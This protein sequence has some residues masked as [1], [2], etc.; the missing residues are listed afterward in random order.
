MLTPEYERILNC[1]NLVD[2]DEIH[3]L[4]LAQLKFIRN[5]LWLSN[6]DLSDIN[7]AKYSDLYLISRN[8]TLEKC[9]SLMTS[10][11]WTLRQILSMQDSLLLSSEAD[12][13]TRDGKLKE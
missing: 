3:I 5:C 2:G 11:S 8:L 13:L 12:S 9:Q 10:T 4:T 6:S 7:V 1:A